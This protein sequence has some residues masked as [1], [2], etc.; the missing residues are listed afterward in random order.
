M[1]TYRTLR[2]I[3]HI[4]SWEHSYEIHIHLSQYL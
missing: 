2:L 4:P 1:I 3:N